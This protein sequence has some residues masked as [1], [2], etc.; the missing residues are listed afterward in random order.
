MLKHFKKF[1]YLESLNPVIQCFDCK[2]TLNCVQEISAKI[3]IVTN[4]SYCKPSI[5]K[6]HREQVNG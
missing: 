2:P 6:S 1:A 5:E 3:V 4:I